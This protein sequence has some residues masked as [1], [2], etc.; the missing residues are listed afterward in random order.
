MAV[1]IAEEDAPKLKVFGYLEPRI[2]ELQIRNTVIKVL[3]TS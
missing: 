2:H 1:K 3:C